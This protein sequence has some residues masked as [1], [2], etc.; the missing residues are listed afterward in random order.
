L[1]KNVELSNLLTLLVLTIG[2]M[3]TVVSPAVAVSSADLFDTM[4]ASVG[5]YNNNVDQVPGIV[6]YLLGNEETYVTVDMNN[7]EK[8]EVKMVMKDAKIVQFDKIIGYDKSATISVATTEKTVTELM[9]SNN[10]IDT[11]TKAMDNGAIKVDGAG[12][13]MYAVIKSLGILMGIAKL[14]GSLV[15]MFK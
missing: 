3:T 10:P 6:K 14:I 4:H 12:I 7:G 1:R 13:Y 2:I 8:L 5:L 9:T 11:F 15:G